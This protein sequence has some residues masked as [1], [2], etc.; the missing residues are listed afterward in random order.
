MFNGGNFV[1][2]MIRLL[3]IS[4]LSV[5]TPLFSHVN[6]NP[7]YF[8]TI[9]DNSNKQTKKSSFKIQIIFIL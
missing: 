1:M 8:F 6:D 4:C 3:N 9:G 5:N 7:W 2:D